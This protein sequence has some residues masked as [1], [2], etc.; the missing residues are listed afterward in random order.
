MT[1]QR[2]H[3]LRRNAAG[4]C[5]NGC[6][7]LGKYADVCDA[8]AEKRRPENIARARRLRRKKKARLVAA[9]N[10]IDRACAIIEAAHCGGPDE[11]VAGG[12]PPRMTPAEWCELYDVLDKARKGK[13]R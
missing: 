1:R 13:G 6:G 11:T 9:E 8:C 5:R 12:R 7:P 2:K 10:A 3:Q 4:L